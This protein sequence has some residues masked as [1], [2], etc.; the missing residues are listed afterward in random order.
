MH[1]YGITERQAEQLAAIVDKSEPSIVMYRALISGTDFYEVS[2][3]IAANIDTNVFEIGRQN[4]QDIN[5]ALKTPR[6]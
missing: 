3:R 5:R 4:T 6:Q 1:V 2:S